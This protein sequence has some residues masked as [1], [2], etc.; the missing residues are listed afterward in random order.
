MHD[1]TL[2]ELF[3]AFVIPQINPEKHRL[4]T[5]DYLKDI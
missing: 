3:K 4:S 5:F 2:K 1:N